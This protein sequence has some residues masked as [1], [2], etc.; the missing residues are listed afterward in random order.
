MSDICGQSAGS[1]KVKEVMKSYEDSLAYVEPRVDA[2]L[3]A[4][5]ENFDSQIGEDCLELINIEKPYFVENIRYAM[6]E[7]ATSE[8]FAKEDFIG[9]MIVFAK[10]SKEFDKDDSISEKQDG[11]NLPVVTR[12]G[13]I[14]DCIFATEELININYEGGYDERWG[15]EW[16]EANGNNPR[17]R[18][19]YR[20]PFVKGA[21]FGFN[22]FDQFGQLWTMTEVGKAVTLSTEWEDDEMEYHVSH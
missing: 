1:E 21:P 8:F 7:W 14:R 16:D 17:N 2:Y 3:E 20:Y 5:K 6:E 15:D 10:S 12:G 22:Y 9:A 13:F 11:M 4:I 18:C 19:N